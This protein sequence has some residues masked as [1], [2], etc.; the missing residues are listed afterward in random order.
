MSS[1]TIES[2]HPLDRQPV[3]RETRNDVIDARGKG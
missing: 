1:W 3:K 2:E